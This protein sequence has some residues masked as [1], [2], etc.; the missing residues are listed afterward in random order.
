[1]TFNIN[2]RF[3]RIFLFL[4]AI[5]LLTGTGYAPEHTGEYKE[6]VT[7]IEPLLAALDDYYGY[8]YLLRQI[9]SDKTI[10]VIRIIENSRY[11]ELVKAIIE[12]ESSWRVKARS[13]KNARGLMQVRP[14]AARDIDPE[15]S[16]HEL[17]DPVTNVRLGVQIFE[18][19]MEYFSPFYETEHWALT[20]YNRGRKG[21]FKLKLDPPRTRYSSKVLDIS[22]A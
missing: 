11:P 22:N 13:H 6:E 12:V 8:Q 1:M 18:K 21:T 5:L 10:E 3:K 14:I 15:I 2:P 7:E 17:Y 4:V 9:G 19:H 20:A 16:Q